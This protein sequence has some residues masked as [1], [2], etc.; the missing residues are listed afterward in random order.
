MAP[1]PC[2]L[3][4]AYAA[5]KEYWNY[6]RGLEGL[7]SYGSDEAYISLKYW[8]SGGKCLILKN[9][10]VGH[11]YRKDAPY[12]FLGIDFVYNKLWISLLTLPEVISLRVL[13]NLQET[14]SVQFN[15]ALC[16]FYKNIPNFIV[17]KEYYKKI[18]TGS[19]E[20]FHKFNS[21]CK[22]FSD[23][24]RVV[25]KT[26]N[27][28]IDQIF[29]EITSK[30]YQIQN[31]GLFHGKMGVAIFLYL[32]SQTIN[33]SNIEELAEEYLDEVIAY[34]EN[35][36]NIKLSFEQGLLGIAWGLSF[37]IEENIIDGDINEILSDF[38]D[39]IFN[40]FDERLSDWSFNTGIIGLTYYSLMRLQQDQSVLKKNP[41]FF[42]LLTKVIKQRYIYEF[43]N[44]D[45][46]EFP[47][48]ALLFLC[49]V[50]N[51][52]NVINNLSSF[53]CLQLLYSTKNKNEKPFMDSILIKGIDSV[54]SKQKK[55]KP[56][57]KFS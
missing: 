45:E 30:E 29:S 32:Y 40:S 26:N 19:F 31:F 35:F 37:L 52:Y 54:L 2:I 25:V 47:I 28:S 15:W 5:H 53:E 39:I 9:L 49:V 23:S 13:N 24:L 55:R 6:L 18:L 48:V 38:D 22:L 20:K 27:V 44:L 16:A 34:V 1:V 42:M 33:N 11:L 50:E 36:K 46:I 14:F 12:P 10:V 17:L 7:V 21:Q 57:E 51:R 43:A 41:V 56:M 4:A 3:G 8:M